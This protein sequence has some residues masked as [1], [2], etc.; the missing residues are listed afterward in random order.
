MRDGFV[1]GFLTL[2]EPGS[3]PGEQQ[4]CACQRAARQALAGHRIDVPADFSIG[5]K[6]VDSASG[7]G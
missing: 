1:T 7:C 5:F 4:Q 2:A 6:D 3:R